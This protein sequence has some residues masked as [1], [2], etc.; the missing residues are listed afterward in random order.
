MRRVL[1]ALAIL[2][3]HDLSKKPATLAG[4]RFVAIETV[5]FVVF[6]A[7]LLAWVQASYG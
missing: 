6:H 7:A 2:I 5:I 1:P 3:D 4:F